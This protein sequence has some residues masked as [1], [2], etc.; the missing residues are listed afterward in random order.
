M[1]RCRADTDNAYL[2]VGI[3]G[4][5]DEISLNRTKDIDK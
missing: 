4:I 2:E 5:D 3:Q 1:Y